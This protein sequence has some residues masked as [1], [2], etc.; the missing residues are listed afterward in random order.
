MTVRKNF[1]NSPLIQVVALSSL[2]L[3]LSSLACS[4]KGS[5][6]TRKDL[7]ATRG[8][9]CPI[10]FKKIHYC[11]SFTPVA[12]STPLKIKT[13][14]TFDLKFWQPSLGTAQGPYSDPGLIPYVRPWMAIHNHGSGKGHDV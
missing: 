6:G 3:I 2:S 9:D 8:P 13:E 11:A 1:K 10:Y 7:A 4:P 5:Q 14:T 12:A